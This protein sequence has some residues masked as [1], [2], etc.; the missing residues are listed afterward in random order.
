[1]VLKKR[2]A[3]QYVRTYL[4][5]VYM[6]YLLCRLVPVSKILGNSDS[7]KLFRWGWLKMRVISFITYHVFSI[8]T[9]TRKILVIFLVKKKVSCSVCILFLF[10]NEKRTN[11]VAFTHEL[12]NNNNRENFNKYKIAIQIKIFHELPIQFCSSFIMI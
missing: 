1:M 12:N 8:P 5:T 11:V 6:V 9:G 10:V 4:C 2:F 7:N 3:A